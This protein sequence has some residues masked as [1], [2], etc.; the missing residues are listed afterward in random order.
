MFQSFDVTTRPENGPAR[1]A[2]P[3]TARR[4]GRDFVA[5]F[6]PITDNRASAE[7]RMR[8]AQNLLLR[9]W[10]DTQKQVLPRVA[11]GRG[12]T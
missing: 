6:T 12:L 10:H 9:C 8:T 7:Y 5:D 11:S 1:L 3:A 4:A 2:A